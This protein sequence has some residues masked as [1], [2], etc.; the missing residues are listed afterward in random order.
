MSWKK[1]LLVRYEI[2]GLLI[3]ILTGNDKYSR[4]NKGNFPQ[5]FQTQLSEKAKTFSQFFIAFLKSTSNS[6]YC[7]RKDDSDSLS[8]S[9]IIDFE[10]GGN[11]NV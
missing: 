4:P 8:I 7:E 11:S 6:D 3:N 2:L 9:E 5:T 1:L 10:R